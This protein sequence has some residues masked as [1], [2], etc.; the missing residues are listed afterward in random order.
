MVYS[1]KSSAYLWDYDEKELQ[2]TE[3]GRIFILERMLNYGP[4]KKKIKLSLVKK[5]WDKLVPNL[6]AVRRRLMELLIWGKYQ[7]SP[8]NKKPFWMG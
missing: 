8:Q 3:K 5:Y 6:F 1:Q 7:S 2:K 4:G